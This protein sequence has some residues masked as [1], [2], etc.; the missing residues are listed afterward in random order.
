M[1]VGIMFL[2]IDIINVHVSSLI[3]GAHTH[4]HMEHN[5]LKMK[6]IQGEMASTSPA[7]TSTQELVGLEFE[8]DYSQECFVV[9]LQF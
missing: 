4:T 8:S 6:E 3:Q 2:L 9:C 1:L 5:S 7:S